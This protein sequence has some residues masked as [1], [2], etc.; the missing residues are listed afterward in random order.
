MFDD[1]P[2]DIGEDDIE[3]GTASAT[4][5]LATSTCATNTLSMTTVAVVYLPEECA[6]KLKVPEL[7]DDMKKSRKGMGGNK[8]IL[9]DRLIKCIWRKHRLVKNCGEIRIHEW[10][11]HYC[12]LG[13]VDAKQFP[14]PDPVKQDAKFSPTNGKRRADQSQVCF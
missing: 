14:I 11:G 4:T 5:T 8:N 3:P 1:Y 7:K 10:A 6:G 9:F 13:S 2:D 12:S